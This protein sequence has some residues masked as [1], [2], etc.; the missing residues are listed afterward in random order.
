M[1]KTLF[2]VSKLEQKQE[3]LELKQDDMHEKQVEMKNRLEM[4]NIYTV[5]V[6]QRQH[7]IFKIVTSVF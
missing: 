2:T 3:Q 7:L 5:V 1:K 4:L 6:V